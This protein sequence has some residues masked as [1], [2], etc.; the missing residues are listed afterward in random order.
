MTLSGSNTGTA[1][2]CLKVPLTTSNRN[3]SRE[4]SKSKALFSEEGLTHSKL[5]QRNDDARERVQVVAASIPSGLNTGTAPCYRH[6][7][8]KR[9]RIHIR[10]KSFEREK[11]NLETRS[12]HPDGMSKDAAEKSNS[13]SSE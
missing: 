4:L 10:S 7:P 2:R 1:P 6:A 12:A 13:G 8:A 11:E 9:S 5:T 3:F